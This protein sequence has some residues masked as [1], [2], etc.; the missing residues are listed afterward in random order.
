MK[1]TTT[2]FLIF[3][4]VSLG[5]TC[6]LLKNKRKKI[7]N[8]LYHSGQ[9][10][11]KRLL[12]ISLK[13]LVKRSD[14]RMASRALRALGRITRWH[15]EKRVFNALDYTAKCAFKTNRRKIYLL[16]KRISIKA[17]SRRKYKLMKL[18]IKE[19]N[20]HSIKVR[21]LFK[22]TENGKRKILRRVMKK[23]SETLKKYSKKG[24]IRKVKHGIRPL[25]GLGNKRTIESL[26]KFVAE[27]KWT[28]SLSVKEGIKKK[29]ILKEL[30]RRIGS[31][32][33]YN[34]FRRIV[35]RLS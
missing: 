12:N 22:L 4:F 27:I 34:F 17:R 1:H 35:K 13:T 7:P 3:V 15:I 21:R 10:A 30:N 24:K 25:K 16:L 32:I 20:N 28:L 29:L 26:N 6:S 11:L 9:Y 19:H 33:I 8:Y 18:I 31:I 5:L 14:C 2:I 23:A